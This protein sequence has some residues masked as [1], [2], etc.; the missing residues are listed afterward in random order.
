MFQVKRHGW[1]WDEVFV[2]VMNNHKLSG[3]S[4]Y[5][6]ANQLEIVARVS[7]RKKFWGGEVGVAV[8]RT[9]TPPPPN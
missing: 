7:S 1:G 5:P 4:S 3:R 8:S 6:S 9:V 2:G